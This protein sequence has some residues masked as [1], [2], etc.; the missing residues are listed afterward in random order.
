MGWANLSQRPVEGRT[1]HLHTYA[2][3]LHAAPWVFMRT[4]LG[5]TNLHWRK[6]PHGNDKDATRE[7]TDIDTAKNINKF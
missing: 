6:K 5:L 7:W 4:F 2:P 1:K 3:E